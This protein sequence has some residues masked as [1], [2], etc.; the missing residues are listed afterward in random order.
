[1][2]RW[3]AFVSDPEDLI[4]CPVQTLKAQVWLNHYLQRKKVTGTFLPFS[5]VVC[6][7]KVSAWVS[8]SLIRDADAQIDNDLM[9][10]HY[11]CASLDG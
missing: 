8:V 4:L 10:L 2:R 11:L 3:P 1:M 9:C 5:E 7:N 6:K